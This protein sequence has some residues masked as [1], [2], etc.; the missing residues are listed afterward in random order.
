MLVGELRHAVSIRLG[1][2]QD[3]RQAQAIVH[4]L[5]QQLEFH[6]T[7]LRRRLSGLSDAEYFWEPVPA[8]SLRI[9]DAGAGILDRSEP[10]PT[11]PPFTTIAWRM[12]HLIGDVLG[13]RANRHFGDQ[14]FDR[15]HIVWPTGAAAALELLDAALERPAAAYDER[16]HSVAVEEMLAV[17]DV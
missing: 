14:R 13:S 9:D 6:W 1:I 3:D 4:E 12:C 10:E 17:R 2:W 15:A 16:L 5:L 8:W 7:H 11:P